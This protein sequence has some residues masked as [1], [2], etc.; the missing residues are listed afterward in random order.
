MHQQVLTE[1]TT[2][3]PLCNGDNWFCCSDLKIGHQN[4]SV[5]DHFRFIRSFFDCR[6]FIFERIDAVRTHIFAPSEM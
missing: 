1:I 6:G 2:T 5:V 3:T 4:K